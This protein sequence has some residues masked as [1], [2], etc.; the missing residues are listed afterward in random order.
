[1]REQM[2]EGIR[3]GSPINDTLIERFYDLE[4]AAVSR[5]CIPRR[6]RLAPG[7]FP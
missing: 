6:A 1:M 5:A 7:A 3:W 4:A 2:E